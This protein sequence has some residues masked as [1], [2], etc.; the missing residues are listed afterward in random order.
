MTARFGLLALLIVTALGRLGLAWGLGAGNDEAY[1]ANFL[2]HPAASYFDQPPMV[3]LVARL[4]AW[5]IGDERSIFGLRLGFVALFAGSTWLMARVGARFGGERAG[6][7][8]ALGLNLAWYFGVAAG[9]FVLPD[10]PLVFFWL[11][12]L[13]RL[14]AVLDR[15]GDWLPWCAV[16]AAWGGALLSKYHA[17]LLFLSVGLFFVWDRG[18]RKALRGWG[19]W[20]AL[21]IG[22]AFFSPVLW[23]NLW[24]GGASFA[25]QAHRAAGPWEFSGRNLAT[26]VLGPMVYLSPWIWAGLVA[27]FVRGVRSTCLG[28]QPEEAIEPAVAEAGLPPKLLRGGSGL[29]AERLLLC[30]AVVPAVF[31]L[32]V[33]LGRPVFPHWA[34]IGFVGLIPL[35]GRRWAADLA[36]NPHRLRSR[37]AFMTAAVCL[38]PALVLG[39]ARCGWF[40]RGAPDAILGLIDP[41]TDPTLDLMGWDRVVEVLRKEG[42]LRGDGP[43][44]FT[45]RWHTSGQMALAVG[46]LA[47]VVCYHSGDAR[48]FA[49]WSDPASWVGQDGILVSVGDRSSEPACFD[50]WFERI[51]SIGRVTIERG[52]CPARVV[53]LFRC[54]RQ[55]RP[56][57]FDVVRLSARGSTGEFGRKAVQ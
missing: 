54:I 28:D 53:R 38:V 56:F 4:G 32:V 19:V 52:G 42:H 18:S 57:P 14:L 44:V 51:E 40:Q 41:K 17:A 2:V 7:L 36:V 33:A 9:A 55:T 10:G 46:D 25:F 43:F 11:L 37:L 24:N 3:A 39:H 48:G 27:C 34:L 23:W 35:L 30:A 12:A 45:G 29:A 8:S 6:L 22:L 49:Y 26:A 20:L 5:L 15:P 21:G 13:D 31:F 47:P 16:G 50:R 1:Y